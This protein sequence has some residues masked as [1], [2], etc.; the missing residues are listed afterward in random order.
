MCNCDLCTR[1]RKVTLEIERL[2]EDRQQFFKELFDYLNH[3]EMDLDYSQAI[4]NGSWPEADGIIATA[5]EKR[6]AKLNSDRNSK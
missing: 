5:R 1:N 3:V 6:G 2:P 4:I